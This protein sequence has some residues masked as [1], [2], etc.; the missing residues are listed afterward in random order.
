MNHDPSWDKELRRHLSNFVQVAWLEYES[1]P[2]LIKS[3]ATV[4]AHQPEWIAI[5]ERQ[6]MSRPLDRIEFM[7]DLSRD[8]GDVLCLLL[9]PCLLAEKR[10]GSSETLLDGL[11]VAFGPL[12]GKPWPAAAK[13]ELLSFTNLQDK[14]LRDEH[15]LDIRDTATPGLWMGRYVKVVLTEWTLRE[16]Y[17][18]PLLSLVMIALVVLDYDERAA[19]WGFLKQ[20]VKDLIS[21]VRVLPSE[22]G[23]LLTKWRPRF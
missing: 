19:C 8:V 10:S 1:N 22:V 2:R 23:A 14:L 7:S 6:A 11:A 12:L 4:G 5:L 16:G 3:W 17:L 13:A 21:E 20:F 15:G 9:C 18:R